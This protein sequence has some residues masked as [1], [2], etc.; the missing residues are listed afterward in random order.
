MSLFNYT[1]VEGYPVC[2]TCGHA[3]MPGHAVMKVDDCMI[4]ASCYAHARAVP[5]PCSYAP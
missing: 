2:P 4:H 1:D 5:E 3:I